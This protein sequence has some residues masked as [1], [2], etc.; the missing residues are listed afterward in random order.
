MP[1]CPICDKSW[2]TQTLLMVGYISSIFW[3][4]RRRCIIMPVQ[5]FKTLE[6]ISTPFEIYSG[7]IIEHQNRAGCINFYNTRKYNTKKVEKSQKKA[8]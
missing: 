1:H 6:P 5:L 3:E 4:T 2:I 8:S 7:K